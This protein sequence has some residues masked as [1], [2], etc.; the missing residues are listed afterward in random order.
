MGRNNLAET[1]LMMLMG[2]MRCSHLNHFTGV[3]SKHLVNE[4]NDRLYATFYYLQMRF[5]RQ[6]PL[7]SFG[8]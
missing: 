8:I 4:A 7:A 5:P 2:D 1:A 3:P 6:T